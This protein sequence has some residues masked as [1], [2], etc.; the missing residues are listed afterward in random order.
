[1]PGGIRINAHGVYISV[2]FAISSALRFRRARIRVMARTDASRDQNIIAASGLAHL[3]HWSD[4]VA[5]NFIKL[6]GFVAQWCCSISIHHLSRSIKNTPHLHLT[7]KVCKCLLLAGQDCRVSRI[8]SSG[9]EPDQDIQ[10]DVSSA[11]DTPFAVVQRAAGSYLRANKPGRK[12]KRCTR[13]ISPDCLRSIH[14]RSSRTC[15]TRVWR[16][17]CLC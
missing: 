15:P 8:S 7:G 3:F 9:N 4:T 13:L 5:V 6:P 17:T 10:I 1:M 12:P 11:T 2:A 16:N 14:P